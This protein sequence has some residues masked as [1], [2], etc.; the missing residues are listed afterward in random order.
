[1]SR[2]FSTN[3]PFDGQ[4]DV[5]ATLA[6][7]AISASIAELRQRDKLTVALRTALRHGATLDELSAASG[8]TP[9]EIR[10]RVDAA[11]L[12]DDDLDDLVG[13]R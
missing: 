8:L 9:S 11:L 7:D 1:M 6:G 5:V 12:I 10:R 13:V 4:L 3:M 2:V